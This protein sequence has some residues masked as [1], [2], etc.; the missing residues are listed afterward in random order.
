[1]KMDSGS[2]KIVVENKIW[3]QKNLRSNIYFDHQN[4]GSK[5]ILSERKFGSEKNSAL[6]IISVTKNCLTQKI[7]WV[8]RMFM[9][10]K[11]SWVRKKC[12][13]PKDLGKKRVLENFCSEIN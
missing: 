10:H 13:V 9:F 12:P 7:I 3:I 11:I 2:K 8:H 6:K 5:K 4:F 1:M